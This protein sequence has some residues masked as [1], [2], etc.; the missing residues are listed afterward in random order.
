MKGR[1]YSEILLY[2]SPVLK[3]SIF[4]LIIKEHNK[5]QHFNFYARKPEY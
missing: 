2:L 5:C 3:K 4:L 1:G